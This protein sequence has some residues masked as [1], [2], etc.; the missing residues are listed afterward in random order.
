[1]P[2]SSEI[3]CPA[4]RSGVLPACAETGISGEK[5][6]AACPDGV[7]SATSE[8]CLIIPERIHLIP[9]GFLSNW[10]EILEKRIENDGR[11]MG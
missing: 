10:K 6:R 11:R 8:M 2:M 7:K 3:R 4:Y 9:R 5:M 1:M